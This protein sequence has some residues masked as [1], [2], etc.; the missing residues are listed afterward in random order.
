MKSNCIHWL[1]SCVVMSLLWGQA[2]SVPEGDWIGLWRLNLE[3]GDN[4]SH[5][6]AVVS[7]EV[8]REKVR[9]F[10]QFW[11][12]QELAKSLIAGADLLVEST[13]KSRTYRF[14]LNRKGEQAEGVWRVV[15]PQ[16]PV[17][18]RLA[19]GRVFRLNHW[20]PMQG[21]NQLLTVD[22]LVDV[23]AALLKKA[24]L[25]SLAKFRAYWISEAELQLFMLIEDLVGVS[26]ADRDAALQTVFS[27]LSKKEYRQLSVRFVTVRQ[28]VLT[29]V[30]QKQPLFYSENPLV[31]MPSIGG[32]ETT[33]D[34]F[35][36]KLYVRVGL[37]RIGRQYPGERLA[38]LIAKEQMKMPLYR[39]LPPNDH[40]IGSEIIR[41][42]VAAY[43]AVALGFGKGPD[44]CFGLPAGAAAQANTKLGAYK[45]ELLADLRSN[46]PE[47]RSK[48]LGAAAAVAPKAGLLVAYQFGEL[49]GKR[50]KPE[51][52]VS[53]QGT[54]L[55][56]LL[57]AFLKEGEK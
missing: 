7:G 51:E 56:D 20:D 54:R 21:V 25:G 9:Y 36:K 12:E 26:P 44:D 34:F 48:H 3:G 32:L 33:A 30:K 13:P 17:K 16:F 31:V 57:I 19:A 46:R 5:G 43:Q 38:C 45:K 8:G 28:K 14:E 6:F 49:V 55:Y 15:H 47:A 1:L 23:N 24:P 52:I 27:L 42:G 10:N 11:E 2:Q 4:P 40:R 53:M 39:S 22:L 37:D 18:G 41:E 35:A 29:D 50:F